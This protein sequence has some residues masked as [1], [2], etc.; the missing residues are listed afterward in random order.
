M[1]SPWPCA[2]AASR[3]ISTRCCQLGRYASGDAWVAGE[4][5]GALEACAAEAMRCG[6]RDRAGAS[7][8]LAETLASQAEREAGNA[9]DRADIGSALAAVVSAATPAASRAP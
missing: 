4:L 6:A 9:Q 5:L 7:L 8:A 2:G 1:G 3:S